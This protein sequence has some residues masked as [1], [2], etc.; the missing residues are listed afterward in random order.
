MLRGN[1]FPTFHMLYFDFKL[2]SLQEF[3][4]NSVK[5]LSLIQPSQFPVKIFPANPCIFGRMLGRP[6]RKMVQDLVGNSW[7]KISHIIE[8]IRLWGSSLSFIISGIAKKCKKDSDIVKTLCN[9]RV[10]QLQRLHVSDVWGC[11]KAQTMSVLGQ[12]C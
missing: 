7:C 4:G 11:R 10:F 1:D 6:R 3:K 8:F 5:K 9:V 2:A 12:G